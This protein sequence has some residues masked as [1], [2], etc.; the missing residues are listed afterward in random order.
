VLDV[1]QVD[2]VPDAI[3]RILL[4]VQPS[5]EGLRPA[6]PDNAF[7]LALV[8]HD[9]AQGLEVLDQRVGWIFVE[10]TKFSHTAILRFHFKR[11]WYW[12]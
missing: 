1:V 3:Q 4:G 12:R 6:E 7:G 11:A 5:W 8:T 9:V 2:L 10:R